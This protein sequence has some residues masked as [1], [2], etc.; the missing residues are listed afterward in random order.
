[1]PKLMNVGDVEAQKTISNFEFSAR[2]IEELGASE[3]TLVVIEVDESG[4]V[5]DFKSEL[6]KALKSAVGACQKHPRSENIMVRTVSFNEDL[7]E[8][9]GFV[10]LSSIN[11]DD[12]DDQINPSGGTAL[13]DATL[14]S[15][16]CVKQYGEN[17]VDMDYSCNAI[18]FIITDGEENS[19]KIGSTDKIKKT[20]QKIKKEEKL[21]SIQTVLVGVGDEPEVQQ[22]LESF[23][24]EVGI[25]Q[26]VWIGDATPA[27]LAKL[28]NFV[29]QSIS[30]TSQALGTGA[31]SQDITF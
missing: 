24:D 11:V 3:Y 23:K 27:K 8:I 29:S 31:P 1:M 5:S 18:M 13:W 14:D 4:S 20:I 22:Y 30:S 9:N 26:F 12:Y 16:E 15:L 6:E 25:D 2:K 28:G 10:E 7:R 19:S 21:E 17:L